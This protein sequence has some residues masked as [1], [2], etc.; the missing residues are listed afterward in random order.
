MNERDFV[1]GV[2]NCTIGARDFRHA[3][4]VRLAWIC[5]RNYPLLEAI[6]RFVSTLRRFAAHHGM[7]EKYHETVTWA[8]LLLI[9]ERMRRG[10][11]PQEWERFR[12]E[13]DDLFTRNP[14]ILERYYAPAT[15]ESDIACKSFVLPDAGLRL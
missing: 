1:A 5:L 11:E 13:N 10:G 2:E 14:S 3:D 6:A 9:H 12:A 7:P 8:Y 4:H 15:L